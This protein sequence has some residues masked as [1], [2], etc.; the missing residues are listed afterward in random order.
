MEGLLLH[1]PPH[2]CPT[3]RRACFSVKKLLLLM[4]ITSPDGILQFMV[5]NEIIFTSL[6]NYALYHQNLEQLTSPNY[7]VLDKCS[8]TDYTTMVFYNFWVTIARLLVKFINP[9]LTTKASMHQTT[10]GVSDKEFK[11]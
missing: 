4:N 2:S 7:L 5:L 10:E 6:P 1:G 9:I 3:T 8:L 11:I